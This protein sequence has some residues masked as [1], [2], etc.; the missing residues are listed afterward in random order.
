MTDHTQ[1]DTGAEH[2]AEAAVGAPRRLLEPQEAFLRLGRLDLASTPLGRVL[3]QVAE[4]ARDTVPGADEVSVTLLDGEEARTAGFTGPLAAQLDERQYA[5]GFGPC[6]DAALGGEV[7][8]LPDLGLDQ[9]YPDFSAV[10]VRHGVRSSLSVGMPVP[11]RQLGGLNIYARVPHAF[12][13]ESVTLARAFA[14]YA[15]VALLNASLLESREALARQLERAM[16][17][18]AV[19]EQAKGI[20]MARTGCSAEEAFAVLARRSQNANRKLHDLAAE[21]VAHPRRSR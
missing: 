5:R 6:M 9:R 1:N 4:L 3:Q 11:Q 2:G 17:S 13:E 15:A 10:A 12:D 16:A 18:R 21:V 20:I 19:I 14:E 8:S 7:V